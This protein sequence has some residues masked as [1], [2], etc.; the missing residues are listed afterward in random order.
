MPEGKTM[1]LQKEG[2]YGLRTNI[3][4]G[5]CEQGDDLRDYKKVTDIV[6]YPKD[7]KLLKDCSK[8]IF[9]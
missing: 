2:V 3:I 8:E 7:N 4:A 5:S 6:D 9:F 1:C